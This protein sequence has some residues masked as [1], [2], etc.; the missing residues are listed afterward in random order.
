MCHK[1]FIFYKNENGPLSPLAISL[2]ISSSNI[3]VGEITSSYAYLDKSNFSNN[4]LFCDPLNGD[5]SV[6]VNSPNII[7]S[8][9]S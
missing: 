5:F 1:V 8:E 7:P 6:A 4:P 9:S 3:R 2:N